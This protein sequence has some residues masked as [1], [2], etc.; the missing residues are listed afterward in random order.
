MTIDSKNKNSNSVSNRRGNLK[1]GIIDTSFNKNGYHMH[2]EFWS[3]GLGLDG[4][5]S[6]R[7]NIICGDGGLHGVIVYGVYRIIAGGSKCPCKKGTIPFLKRR[8]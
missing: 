1:E 7:S 4:F 2:F 3:L 6:D 5:V 8:S